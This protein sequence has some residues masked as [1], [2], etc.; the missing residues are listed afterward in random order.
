MSSLSRVSPIFFSRN[1]IVFY[2]AQESVVQVRLIFA[3][4]V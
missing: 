3:R 2:L 4:G 1:F